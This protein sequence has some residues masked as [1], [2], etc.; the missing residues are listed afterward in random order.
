VFDFCSDE[1][2]LTI[3][4]KGGIELILEAMKHH[5]THAAIQQHSCAALNNVALAGESQFVF[6]FFFFSHFNSQYVQPTTKYLLQRK[7][8][9]NLSCKQ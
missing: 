6:F 9:L 1:N 2:K 5:S 4:R 3:R 7:E 8:A